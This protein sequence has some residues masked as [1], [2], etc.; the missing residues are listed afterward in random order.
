MYS[1][2]IGVLVI[3]L[4]VGIH[5]EIPAIEDNEV[6]KSC[7]WSIDLQFPTVHAKADVQASFEKSLSEVDAP[8]SQ[9]H[10]V[11]IARKPGTSVYL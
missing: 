6:C 2:F 1:S 10:E 9:L 4:T 7:A 5:E 8:D 3:L 11:R